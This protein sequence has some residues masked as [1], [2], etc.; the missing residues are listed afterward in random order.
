[1]LVSLEGEKVRRC[2]VFQAQQRPTHDWLIGRA[3][4]MRSWR[5]SAAKKRH[6]DFIPGAPGMFWADMHLPC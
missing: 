5:T 4:E 2:G 3:A 6:T 1:M